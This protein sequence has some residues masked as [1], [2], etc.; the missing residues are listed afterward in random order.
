MK[1][2]VGFIGLGVIGMPMAERLLEQ[3]LPLA[4]WNRTAEKAETLVRRGAARAA[5][6][7]PC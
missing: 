1:T 4:V 2:A 6:S 3:G 5:S 7:S